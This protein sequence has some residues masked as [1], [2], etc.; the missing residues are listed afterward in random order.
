MVLSVSSPRVAAATGRPLSELGNICSVF[1]Q[2]RASGL[3]CETGQ[4]LSAWCCRRHLTD[5]LGSGFECDVLGSI[6]HFATNLVLIADA[7]LS[8][9]AS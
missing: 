6:D 8:L 7:F 9:G 5:A 4:S 2:A 1:D 3:G